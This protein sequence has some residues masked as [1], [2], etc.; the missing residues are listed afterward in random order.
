MGLAAAQQAY[1][2]TPGVMLPPL[3]EGWIEEDDQV[4]RTKYYIHVESGKR[5]WLRPG[6]SLQTSGPNMPMMPPPMNAPNAMMQPPPFAGNINTRPPP[7]ITHLPPPPMPPMIPPGGF[8]PPP[9]MPMG[10]PLPPPFPPASFPQPP[11]TG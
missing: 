3:P 9:P 7:S 10:L 2:K 8:L 4:T 6:F 5:Q 11:R 1:A